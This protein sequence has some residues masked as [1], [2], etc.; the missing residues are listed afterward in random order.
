MN[1]KHVEAHK[2]AR[3]SEREMTVFEFRSIFPMPYHSAHF[4]LNKY[5]KYK[6]LYS[7]KCKAIERLPKLAPPN[8]D[9]AITLDRSIDYKDF[10]RRAA[11]RERIRQNATKRGQS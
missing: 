8:N 11:T 2:Y 1:L 4:I 6:S 10:D 9:H 7:S 3:K 5:C